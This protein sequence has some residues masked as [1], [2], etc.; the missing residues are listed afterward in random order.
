MSNPFENALSQLQRAFSLQPFDL[1]FQERLH[2]PNREI[3]ISIPVHMDDG[4][5]KIFTGY[6]VQYN[7]AR[8]PYKG[9]IRYHEQTD[10]HEVRALAFWMTLKC[11]VADIPLGGGKGGI[12]VNPKELSVHELEQL[13]RAWARGMAEVIGP[14]KDI[15]A[16]DVNTSPRE[17]D[18]IADE[19]AKMNLHDHPKAVITG[20]TIEAGGSLGRGTATADGGYFLFKELQERLGLG[21]KVKVVIQGFGNAGSHMAELFYQNGHCVIGVSDSQGG[22]YK[23]DGLDIQA[24]IKQKEE[25]GSVKDFP[26]SVFVSNEALLEL[27]CDVLVPAALEN[28]ITKENANRIQAKAI[29][30]LANGPVTPEADDILFARGITS[31]PD[32][33]AN[34]GGVTVSSFEWEQ[35]LKDEV[36]TEEQVKEKLEAKMKAALEVVWKKKEKLG[37]DMRQAAFIV[38]LERIQEAMKNED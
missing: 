8:G 35:N 6:R 10:I 36:W 18:W 9:G 19:Y 34:S 4:S 37:C 23:E 12:E 3:M 25:T 33:L 38:A 22:I 15:P 14:R 11:A 5:L 24:V 13:T 31:V 27:P 30:E 32:I 29:I 28:Q 16:P 21:K 17:M 26:G 20:K 1:F 2:Q 7:N